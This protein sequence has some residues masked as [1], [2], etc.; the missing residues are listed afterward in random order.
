[1]NNKGQSLVL[2]VLVLPICFLLI[3][4][5][6]SEIYLN[7]EKNNIEKIANT[8]CK[9]SKKEEDINKIIKLGLK[10]DKDLDIG[11]NR[12]NNNLEI[13]ILKKEKLFNKV[14]FVKTLCE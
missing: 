11:I 13:I 4:Y 8:L 1:M 3:F 10:N 7:I 5:I 14:I 2:F 9:Y 12:K 6:V